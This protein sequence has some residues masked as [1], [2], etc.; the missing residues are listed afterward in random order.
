MKFIF[1]RFRRTE[2]IYSVMKEL[3]GQCPQNFGARTAPASNI[4]TI[5]DL[6]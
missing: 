4:L 1:F 5:C 3:M 2:K 6:T